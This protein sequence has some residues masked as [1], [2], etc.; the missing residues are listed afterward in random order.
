MFRWIKDN[1]PS[2]SS[3]SSEGSAPKKKK[4]T[5]LALVPVAVMLLGGGLLVPHS[6]EPRDVP[7]PHVDMQTL[8]AIEAHDD[9]LARFELTE[10]TQALGR[11]IR[12]FFD[13]Q[14]HRVGSDDLYRIQRDL[15][16]A[17]ETALLLDRE[18]ALLA[19]RANELTRFLAETRSFEVSGSPS[20]EMV[21]LSGDFVSPMR[22]IG[23]IRGTRLIIDTH[24]LRAAYKLMWNKALGLDNVAAFKLELD[25]MRVLYMFLMTHPSV[26][27]DAQLRSRRTVARTTDECARLERDERVALAQ[28]ALQRVKN[29]AQLDGAYP[30]QYALGVAYYQAGM[31][32]QAAHSFREWMTL[33]PSGDYAARARN[34]AQAALFKESG[35]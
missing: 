20:D 18:P 8:E 12:E 13:A 3:L 30:K 1:L 21:A 24:A 35:R 25:E 22:D 2:L 16:G 26:G 27:D 6:V 32:S 33:H 34:Y 15:G 10:T 28:R 29:L 7:L 17:R 19:L 9:K 14:V 31:Y 23:W 4:S 11:A 5:G